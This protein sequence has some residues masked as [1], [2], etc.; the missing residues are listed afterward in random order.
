MIRLR[1]QMLA[2][3]SITKSWNRRMSSAVTV[4][5]ERPRNAANRAQPL[6]WLRWVCGCRLRAVMSSIMR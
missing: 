1:L 6:R 5:G 2:P 4:S 3:V